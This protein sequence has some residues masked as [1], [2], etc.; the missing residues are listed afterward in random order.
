MG[1]KKA[2]LVLLLLIILTM[3][4]ASAADTNTTSDNLAATEDTNLELSENDNFE[5]KLGIDELT[6]PL[7]GPGNS[8]GKSNSSGKFADLNTL[9]SGATAGDTVILTE[10]YCKESDFYGLISIDKELT[11]DGQGHTL[12]ANNTRDIIRIDNAQNV[13]LKN[14]QFINV[15]GN[16]STAVYW[17]YGSDNGL[18]E[19]CT[20]TNCLGT[21][22]SAINLI[23]SNTNIT[24]STFINCSG[25][26]G[27]AI[28]WGGNDNTIRYSYFE[29][30]TANKGGAI[31][32]YGER[33]RIEGT[34]FKNCNMPNSTVIYADN[35]VNII[36]C[37][38]TTTRNETLSSLVYNGNLTNCTLNGISDKY[39]DLN[40]RIDSNIIGTCK[41]GDT[42]EL[43]ATVYNNG[44]DDAKNVSAHF[45]IPPSL[46]II[47]NTPYAGSFDSMT[48][49]WN[50]PEIFSTSWATLTIT[51]QAIKAENTTVNAFVSSD[52]KDLNLTDNN[53]SANLFIL[54]A[55]TTLTLNVSDIFA[56]ETLRIFVDITPIDATGNLT[57]NIGGV[58]EQSFINGSDVI[59]KEGL[60]AGEYNITVTYSGNANYLP[61]QSN[62]SF[63]VNKR[64][65]NLTISLD[66]NTITYGQNATLTAIIPIDGNIAININNET[67][68]ITTIA[69]TGHLLIPT[70]PAGN[71]TI[72]ATFEG[73][74][75]YNPANTT[76]MLTI[77]KADPPIT[78]NTT[79]IKYGQNATITV[80]TLP[81]ATGNLSISIDGKIYGMATIISGTA[82]FNI[83]GLTV[84][85]HTVTATYS[86]DENYNPAN[87]SA[88]QTV[89][90]ADVDLGISLYPNATE[91]KRGD[92]V[93]FIINLINNGPSDATNITVNLTLP[94]SLRY[95]SSNTST[96]YED[97]QTF[98]WIIDRLNANN[99]AS[100]TFYCDV[101]GAGIIA[102]NATAST[103]NEIDTYNTN[104]AA[105]LL[106]NASESKVVTPDK[107]DCFFDKNGTLLNVSTD[108]LTFEGE[109]S[110]ITSA[111]TINKAITFIGNNTTFKDVSF[112][113]KSDH[114]G[115][116]NFTIIS[117]NATGCAINASSH[118]NILLSNNT[119]IYKAMFDSDAYVLYAN[120]TEYLVFNNNRVTYTGN[121]NGTGKNF[122]IYLTNATNAIMTGNIFNIS[123][124]STDFIW[125]DVP[126][127]SLN[128]VRSPIS[129]N[130]AVRDSNCPVLDSN[131]I[132]TGVVTSFGYYDTIYV[133]DFSGT[134]GSV[135]V[136]NN[137]TS[138]GKDYIY[139]II[140][141]DNDFTIRANNIKST[142]DYYANGIDIEGPAAGVVEYNVIEVK[143][144]LSAYGIYSN[145]LDGNA[146]A[147]YTDNVIV[148]N[149]YNVFGFELDNVESNV[150]GNLVNLRGNYTTGIAYAGSNLIAENNTIFADASNVGNEYV[151]DLFGSDTTEIK[152]IGDN[153]IIKD[154]TINSTDK[155]FYITGDYNELFRNN[156]AGSVNVSGDYNTI[157][158]N[159]INTTEIYAVNLGSSKQNTV[160]DNHLYAR[161]LFGNDAVNFTDASNT[162]I[163]NHPGSTFLTV[164]A[165][166]I[167][168]GDSLYIIVSVTENATGKITITNTQ[169]NSTEYESDIF[170]GIAVFNM[171]GFDVGNYT[172]N[173]IYSGD[174]NYGPCQSNFT[175]AV[176]KKLV[177][178]TI[179]AGD[180]TYGEAATIT[181]T[182]PTDATG[183]V[184]ICIGD[185]N[186]AAEII[187]GEATFNITG[188]G[189]GDYEAI[190]NYTGD[191]NYMA[192]QNTTQFRVS[193]A[194]TEISV[195]S[196]VVNLKVLE[197]FAPEATLIPDVGYLTYI[198]NDTSIAIV[199]NGTIKAI[200]AGST[201]ITV[202]FEG[203]D[204]YE[205]SNKTIN[206]T[207]TL[208]DASI[209][210]NNSTVDLKVGESFS[211]AA[212]TIPDALNVTYI[213]DDSG[214]V[215]VSENGVVTALKE[216]NGVIT[217]RVGGDGIYAQNSTTVNVSVGKTDIIL[218]ISTE[219][220]TYG[221]NATITAT[222]TTD[223]TVTVNINNENIALEI[224]NGTG[225]ITI[226]NLNA[227]EYNIKATFEGN[228]H[229]K[230]ANATTTLTVAKA[231][232]QLTI[233]PIPETTQGENINIIINVQNDATGTITLT[234][235]GENYIKNIENGQVTFNITGLDAGNYE[236][237]ANYTGDTN[238][239]ASQN[240]TQFTVKSSMKTFEDIA[241]I[242]SNAHAG[243]TI[244][245]EGTYYGTGSTIT[246][247]KELTIKGNG[248]TILD[249]KNLSGI[250]SV[251]ANN[252]RINNIRFI[253]G[254]INANGGAIN[255]IGKNGTISNCTFINCSAENGGSVYWNAENGRINTSTFDKSTATSNGGAIYWNANNGEIANSIFTNSYAQNGGAVYVPEN[256][257]VEIKS[258]IFDN[259]I[260]EE[261]SGAVYGGTVDEDCT[262]KNNTYTP[263]NTTTIISINETA[264]YTGN[265]ISITTL[266][267]SQKGGLVNTG[268]VEIYIN[269]KLIAT[270]PANTAY[271][272][273]TGDLGTY[274]VLAKFIDDSSYKD[275]S[276]TAEFTVIP[277]DI[278]EEIETSTAGI[279]TLEFPDDAEGTLTVFI[280]GTKYKVYDIIGGILKIDLSDKKGKYNITFEYSGDKN[281]P[282]FKKDANITVETNPS[283]TASNAKVIYSAGTTYKITVYK[284]KGITA[285]SVSVVI[286]Q[287]NKK[288]KTIKTNSKG[289]ASFKV[290][291]TPGTY[292]LKITSLGKTVTKTL[293]V[294]HI[295]TL[296]TATV[297]KSAKKLILQAT[298][299]KVNKKYLKKK[300]V[301]FKFNGKKY[302]AKTNAKGVAKVTIKSNV[303]KK[304]KVGKKITYQATYLKDTIKK[305]VKVQK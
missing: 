104:N 277:V 198:S 175:V 272:Y 31:Y 261:E 118:S 232:S 152:V 160:R 178:M 279:F 85:N 191:A 269:S 166:D 190:A 247:N 202:N 95:K 99:N 132:N 201:I 228:D 38:F 14:I 225:Q 8:S 24:G 18:I 112:I 1:F 138:I 212:T 89:N 3:G 186:Y 75:Q 171:T 153:S 154:N 197:E 140:I 44:P 162:V 265:E 128:W 48:G 303:L 122:A 257:N 258:S 29:N 68:N 231:Q 286:K 254:K 205:A 179:T 121:T 92:T 284:N 9:I 33:G 28:Y 22:G 245:L 220:T 203:N 260:A 249:A 180:I 235:N 97:S 226:P 110:N 55:D 60:S 129:G 69:G 50:I 168:Y 66:E 282:A 145:R 19:N 120:S 13:K 17:A 157:T 305:T 204:N 219:D 280:D 63:R 125:F 49:I 244:N 2:I 131:D 133:V 299:A 192:C 298:L 252:V 74:D 45:A 302:K 94:N 30:T 185:K 83:P 37:E 101:M 32:L 136:N 224:T 287:N 25:Y 263:L 266:I 62:L 304:L 147:T 119:I 114:V 227:G 161:E 117:E 134:S 159:I 215:S 292:K 169:A 56:G 255:W 27:G 193:K 106:I 156:A 275:S 137:I 51:C 65:V 214:V 173:V 130:I 102:L 127:G 23:G 264:V 98:I 40:M 61:A 108:E 151:Y 246:V 194:P 213:P 150:T 210:V 76:I 42:I 90:K 123:L 78:I 297:K 294:K 248:E 146:S 183:T 200:G 276:S 221:E 64:N 103:E 177:D 35:I 172:F 39:A 20:F 195:A 300:T 124:V 271:I 207:V 187:N 259:N 253:N 116:V 7:S 217:V 135:I 240:S 158:E 196:D 6:T 71:H 4:A 301:T 109:F 174:N 77:N 256:R 81:D 237:I 270:I 86:G 188:L 15:K 142:G 262:F 87:K 41:I 243:D 139:G 206:V 59:M 93:E 105:T 216:G 73:N 234:V 84:G 229:Y 170:D 165:T 12:D 16:S 164:N 241:N 267:L 80:T 288:F 26:E 11:I 242:I 289:I 36:G 100:I 144:G 115:I 211:I 251:S 149:A 155:S 290:T 72:T 296:K 208:N 184:T 10:D 143:S 5:E 34:T 182:T 274:Q 223:G 54:R 181:V 57:I 91:F 107:F 209:S 291:Q 273:K 141:S 79:D 163:S 283:I 53:A 285:N 47:G 43:T 148:G 230:A 67:Y 70:Q 236:A 199:L 167:S 218:T 268:T 176:N 250:L 46:E 222:M 96:A 295:V 293:T 111:I 233:Q 281:Y 278:P 126:P 239:L 189:A 52:A 238:Y 82:A 21:D 113:V 88:T 58:E